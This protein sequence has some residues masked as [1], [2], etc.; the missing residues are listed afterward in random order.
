MDKS[1][2][3]LFIGQGLDMFIAQTELS[4]PNFVLK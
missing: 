4:Q 1:S 2:S 3:K